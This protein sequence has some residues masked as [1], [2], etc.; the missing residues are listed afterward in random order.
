VT[1][2]ELDACRKLTATLAARLALR[3]IVLRTTEDDLGRP[4]YVASLGAMT[5]RFG[6]LGELKVWVDQVDGQ[7]G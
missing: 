6:D 1:A 4:C 5:K 7:R 2:A 3:G